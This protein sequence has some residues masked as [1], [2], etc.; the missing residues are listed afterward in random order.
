MATGPFTMRSPLM[1]TY[2]QQMWLIAKLETDNTDG[3]FIDQLY[4]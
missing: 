4:F 1:T 3:K 2:S